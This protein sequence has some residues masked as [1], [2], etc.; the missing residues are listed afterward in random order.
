MVANG[1]LEF[2]AFCGQYDNHLPSSNSLQPEMHLWETYWTSCF[3]GEIS[4]TVLKTIQ[5]TPQ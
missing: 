1:N 2:R 5:A 3:K 4:N